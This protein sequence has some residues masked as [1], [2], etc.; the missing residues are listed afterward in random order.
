MTGAEDFA[1]QILEAVED[2]KVKRKRLDR[3]MVS[4]FGE[5]QFD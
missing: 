5:A 1:E 2:V 3:K 4:I